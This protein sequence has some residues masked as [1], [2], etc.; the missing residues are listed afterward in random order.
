M[1]MTLFDHQ[2]RLHDLEV[3]LCALVA[4][5]S[6]TPSGQAQIGDVVARLRADG[7]KGGADLLVN[8]RATAPYRR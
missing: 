6:T 3:V 8:G 2:Q 1:A 4:S 5:F 7:E